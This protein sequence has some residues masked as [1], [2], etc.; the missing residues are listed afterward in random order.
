[1]NSRLPESVLAQIWDLS[2]IT[3]SG[4]LSKDEFAVAM[5]LINRKNASNAPIPNTLP[6][7]MIPPSLRNRNAGLSFN[8]EPI[9]SMLIILL[10][11]F[12]LTTVAHELILNFFSSRIFVSTRC[13]NAISVSSVQTSVL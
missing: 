1:M 10:L 5:L 13:H 11:Y 2:D 6:L 4:S 8:Q 12:C 9:R 3:G 7:S